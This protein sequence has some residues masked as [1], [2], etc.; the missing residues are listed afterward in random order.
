MRFELMM[1]SHTEGEVAEKTR[2]IYNRGDVITTDVNLAAVFGANKFR[3]MDESEPSR[4]TSKAAT[5]KPEIDSPIATAVLP[6]REG[7]N[8]LTNKELRAFAAEE[9]VD[10]ETCTS[11][12]DLVNTIVQSMGI[13]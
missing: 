2:K 5:T 9:E 7:L 11:K 12:E 13:S 1:G 4:A 8:K 3:K 6:T 10:V